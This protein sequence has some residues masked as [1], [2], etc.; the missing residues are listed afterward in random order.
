[1]NHLAKSL[2]SQ[3]EELAKLQKGEMPNISPAMTQDAMKA[4]NNI[5][6]DSPETRERE[7][8]ILK[9]LK[10]KGS[11]DSEPD[12]KDIF[13]DDEAVSE[14]ISRT[15]DVTEEGNVIKI[16]NI[17]ITNFSEF[18][19]AV[20]ELKDQI[21]KISSAE[22]N[23]QKEMQK[24]LQDILK[25]Q[26]I[27]YDYLEK[28][29]DKVPGV[30]D[31]MNKPEK[32]GFMEQISAI[33]QLLGSVMAAMKSG[34]WNTVNDVLSDFG[35]SKDITK[36]AENMK[37]AGEAYQNF[38]EKNAPGNVNELLSAYLNPTGKEANALFNAKKGD[39]LGKYRS[40]A[41][42]PMLQ[43]IQKNM[44]MNISSIEAEAGG[45]STKIK[46]EM[47]KQKFE[48]SVGKDNTMTIYEVTKIDKSAEIEAKINEIKNE[49]DTAK[50]SVAQQE[51]TKLQ[52][53]DGKE[54]LKVHGEENMTFNGF[55]N[56]SSD[57]FT[58]HL[59]TL[60]DG[61]R[62]TTSNKNETKAPSQEDVETEGPGED[63]TATV[64]AEVGAEAAETENE[65]NQAEEPAEA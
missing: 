9:K 8:K 33:I 51:L 30:T 50:T 55:N 27:G 52:A 46:A 38:F 20:P 35:E 10:I 47:G 56:G 14:Y 28:N 4:A 19:Q 44:G 11:G 65:G 60:I 53:E 24:T 49:T 45:S 58:G 37:K 23:Q 57:S 13:G 21:A 31:L 39:I 16:N 29:M 61:K 15:C 12:L 1:M 34:D 22:G 64:E 42:A 36:V 2:A 17:A 54:S 62:K 40:E 18:K 25:I 3:P 32:K 7:I 26:N 43:Y 48:I 6:I 59:D 5:K 41:K 63:A